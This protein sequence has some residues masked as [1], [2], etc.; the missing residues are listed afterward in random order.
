MNNNTNTFVE[1][2]FF[3]YAF[4]FHNEPFLNIIVSQN[5]FILN[6][7]KLMTW[8]SWIDGVLRYHCLARP[9]ETKANSSNDLE[10]LISHR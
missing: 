1:L 2:C 10:N 7:H 5:D 9:F 3:Q 4:L 8:V 6:I